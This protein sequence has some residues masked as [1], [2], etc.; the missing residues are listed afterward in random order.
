[1]SVQTRYALSRGAHIAYQVLS[2]GDLDVLIVPSFMSNIDLG[3]GDSSMGRFV[4][5]L[6]R[7]ARVIQFDRRGNGMSDGTVGASTLEEQLDDVTAVLEASET[8]RPA[9]LG[10]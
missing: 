7:F 1:M 10:Y 3:L 4:E 2:E 9:I 8:R 5:R 6:T